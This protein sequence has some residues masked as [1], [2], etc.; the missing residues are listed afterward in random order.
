LLPETPSPL[1]GGL[2]KKAESSSQ[3]YNKT[4]L[5]RNSDPGSGIKA[6]QLVDEEPAEEFSSDSSQDPPAKT[7]KMAVSANS[8]LRFSISKKE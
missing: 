2:K 6:I 8:P 7:P 3:T 1:N 5:L 4:A